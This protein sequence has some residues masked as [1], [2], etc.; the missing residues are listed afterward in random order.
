MDQNKKIKKQKGVLSVVEIKQLVHD[1]FKN[2][3]VDEKMVARSKKKHGR[4][5]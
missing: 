1:I 4:R 3:K 5:N 2:K